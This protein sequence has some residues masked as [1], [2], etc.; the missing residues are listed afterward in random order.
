[1]ISEF[2][3]EYRFL[4]NFWMLDSPIIFNGVSFSTTEHFYQAM[5]STDQ[6]V[7]LSVSKHPIKGLKKFSRGLVLRPDWDE[8]KIDVMECAIDFKFSNS[9]QRLRDMLLN[10][11]DL[12]IQ[13]GNR[14]GDT[15]W[16]YCLKN[17]YGENNLG[18]IL[19]NKRLEIIKDV[20]Q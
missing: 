11:G 16:G 7:I 13:E 15:F 8:I 2:Q 19:M 3:G 5:K 14:W 12:Y 1:M 10:T 20:I 17:N 18:K 6:E 9:N 4:S